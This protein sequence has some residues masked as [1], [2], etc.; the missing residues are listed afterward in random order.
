MMLSRG[1]LGKRTVI[2]ISQKECYKTVLRRAE[3]VL[4]EKRSKFIATV[5]PADTEEKALDFLQ[6]M[7]KTYSDATHNVYAYVI[8]EN[9]IFRYSDD[10]EPSGTAG[11]PVLDTIR[12]A[13]I[14]DCAV[15]V[16]RYFGGTL[17]GTGG[18]VHAYG[19]AAREGLLAAGI[20]E[21]RLCDI[22]T[23]TVDYTTSGRVSHFLSEG[24]HIIE[25]TVYDSEVT[26]FVCVTKSESEKFKADI[27]ELTNG[28]AIIAENGTKYIDVEIGERMD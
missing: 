8:D 21:R 1:M 9:N 16:T 5:I 11:M 7:R 27:T 3:A 6:E 14:V 26:Y 23:V 19:G 22:I 24:G 20:I 17:L 2:K 12:K 4:V 10:N 25:D 13:G 28:R 15:V 18:L